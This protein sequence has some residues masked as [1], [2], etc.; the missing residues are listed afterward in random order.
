[1]KLHI[2]GVVAIALAS[3]LPSPQEWE[4]ANVEV[5]RLDPGAFPE[6]PPA[7]AQYLRDRGCTIPQAFTPGRR[8]GVIKGHFISGTQLDWAV[9]CSASRISTILVFRSGG[10]SHVDELARRDDADYL[11][12]I[13]D[14]R[15]IGYSRAIT[16]ATPGEIRRHG[17]SAK[18]ARLDHDGIDDAF[19]EKGST[20]LYWYRGRWLE[21]EGSN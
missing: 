4:R 18:S 16:V 7:V 10:T 21:L 19:V 13:D 1:M 17:R 11:Q 12:V 2:L 15:R 5:R 14:A 6:L 3:Q 20:I 8:Q 9:L